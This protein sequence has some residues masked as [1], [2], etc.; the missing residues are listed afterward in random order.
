[1]KLLS[2]IKYWITTLSLFYIFEAVNL[3]FGFM[4]PWA[5]TV[6]FVIVCLIAV[7]F[8]IF[9]YGGHFTLK[10]FEGTSH[11]EELAS[12]AVVS[13]KILP[14]ARWLL[15]STLG[16]QIVTFLPLPTT[17]FNV[18]VDCTVFVDLYLILFRLKKY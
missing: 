10:N 9:L 15:F 17:A 18:L 6:I 4:A 5:G 16:V 8:G 13:P 3:V 12:Q 7:L 14:W 2:G 1:M 11:Y